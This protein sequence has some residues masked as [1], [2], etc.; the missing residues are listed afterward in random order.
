MSS[1]WFFWPVYVA[2]AWLVVQLAYE[3]SRWRRLNPTVV[4]DPG[5]EARCGKCGYDVR[6]LPGSICP[7]CGSD[8]DEVGRVAPSY[9]RWQKV[10]RVLRGFVFL[11]VCLAVAL[12]ATAVALQSFVPHRTV[13]SQTLSIS[14][15]H[16][17]LPGGT[18]TSTIHQVEEIYFPPG[19]HG[20]SNG[21]QSGYATYEIDGAAGVARTTVD[22][23]MYLPLDDP[24]A[25]KLLKAME[26]AVGVDLLP[27]RVA[28]AIEQPS[29]DREA[30][31]TAAVFAAMATKAGHSGGA[32]PPDAGRRLKEILR[33]AESYR[34]L[35]DDE[36]KQ[37]VVETSDGRKWVERDPA[38][39]LTITITPLT[40]NSFVPTWPVWY[41][42]LPMVLLWVTV[43]VV[44]LWLATRGR[45]VRLERAGDAK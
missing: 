8:L 5:D 7:E 38:E 32:I 9:G 10:P 23:L 42:V 34:D 40:F 20:M 41:Y 19:Q 31:A 12:P 22:S 35:V 30:G 39:R 18:L 21:E 27:E 37:L 14:V 25:A 28:A 2:L 43:L 1:P 44:G 26:A 24:A 45:P 17:H 33:L 36:A 15:T 3:G 29:E 13:S 6:G 11:L 16:A 4:P